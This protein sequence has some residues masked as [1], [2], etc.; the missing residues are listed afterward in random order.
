MQS[1]SFSTA[2]QANRRLTLR[3]M[4]GPQSAVVAE[5]GGELQP[6]SAAEAGVSPGVKHAPYMYVRSYTRAARAKRQR[7]KRHK[8][9]AGSR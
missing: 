1:N 4:T 2:D 3:P 5:T 7:H 8:R 6:I 9:K